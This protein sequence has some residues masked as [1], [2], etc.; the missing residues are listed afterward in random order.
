MAENTQTTV[1]SENALSS[2]IND[3]QIISNKNRLVSTSSL[4][5]TDGCN[6][7]KDPKHLP[8]K[9]NTQDLP[10]WY[11]LLFTSFLSIIFTDNELNIVSSKPL[12]S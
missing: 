4:F 11:K 1:Q 5:A 7:P 9:I 8:S 2:T 3:F 6:W 12:A 10:G